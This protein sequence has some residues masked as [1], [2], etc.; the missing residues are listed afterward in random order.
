MRRILFS[1]YKVEGKSRQ[2]LYKYSGFDIGGKYKTSDNVIF[3]NDVD[4]N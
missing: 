4:G 3:E 1:S 2:N